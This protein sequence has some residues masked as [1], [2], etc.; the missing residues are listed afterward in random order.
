M[1][2]RHSRHTDDFSLKNAPL[3]HGK[4][5]LLRLSSM[6]RL[7]PL[8]CLCVVL[9]L[10]LLF[11][12][13]SPAKQKAKRF[14]IAQSRTDNQRANTLFKLRERAGAAQRFAVEKGFSG[15][16]AFLLDM[17]LPSGQKRFFIYDLQHDSLLASGLVAH[18]SCNNR[19][20]EA[21][22]FAN[23]PGCGCSS[24]GKY[25]IGGAYEGRFGKAFKLVGLDSTNSNAYQRAVVLHAYSCVPDKEC[26][27]SPL[28]NSLGCAMVSYNFLRVAAGF[29]QKEKQPVLLWMYF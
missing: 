9:P 7:F 1:R 2:G 26:Y 28:C 4:K 29:I 14:S 21:A 17:R 6:N 8:F 23:T 16:V 19:F 15:H 13:S 11:F 18:G 22:Q 3:P 10:I 25:K 5:K 12:K 27:P 24:A 20:L